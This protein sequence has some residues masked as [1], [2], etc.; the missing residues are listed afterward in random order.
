[1]YQQIILFIIFLFL[2]LR[3]TKNYNKYYDIINYKIF[4]CCNASNIII[5]ILLLI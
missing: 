5:N 4:N 3:Y 2:Y 1:M